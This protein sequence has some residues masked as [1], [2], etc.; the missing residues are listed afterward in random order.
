MGHRLT[1]ERSAMATHAGGPCAILRSVTQ[2]TG[3]H[4]R[5]Q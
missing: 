3:F 4:R 5:H 2:V 1:E